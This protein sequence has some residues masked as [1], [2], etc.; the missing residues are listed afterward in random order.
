MVERDAEIRQQLAPRGHIRAAL[1]FGNPVLA[2]RG[3]AHEGPRGIT[4]ALARELGRRLACP[5]EFIEYESAAQVVAAAP[6][7]R[8]DVGFLAADP[9]RARVIAF[10]APYVLLDGTFL[11]R[12]SSPMQAIADFDHAGMRIAVGRGAAYDLHLSRSLRHAQLLRAETSA[13]AVQ[14]FVDEGLEAVAGVRQPLAAYAADHPGFRVIDGSFHAIT[15]AVGVPIGR[16]AAQE[17]LC[18][19]I[20]E[21]KRTGFVSRALAGAA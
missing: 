5:V 13:A 10:T 15:Q 17:Y 2:Q 11:V 19:F 12:A 3:K 20:E 14:L 6:A 1:N 16:P 9:D 21:M 18:T 4:V 8:W 7:D